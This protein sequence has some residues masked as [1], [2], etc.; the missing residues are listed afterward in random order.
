[1]GLKFALTLWEK[2]HT[3]DDENK[4]LMKILRAEAQKGTEGWVQL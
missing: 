4:L 3:K 2:S 1:M